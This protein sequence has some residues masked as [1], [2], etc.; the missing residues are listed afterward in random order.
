MNEE[1]YADVKKLMETFQ[2][3]AKADWRRETR[4]GIKA[5]EIRALLAIQDICR[6]NEHGANVSDISKKLHV[7]S[8][9]ITQI[10]KSLT[11]HGLIE[12]S[13]DAR[14]KRMTTIKLT[15]RGEEITG[16]AMARYRTVFT[17]LKESLGKEQT[18]TLVHLLDQ[19][20]AY[21]KEASMLDD[22]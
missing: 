20:Y 18:D 15:A 7:T 3:F 11:A 1:Q 10:M 17:G 2:R 22:E 12:R 6:Y 8:P 9:T 21:F 4:W 19:V 5:S 16:K 13:T 14:D